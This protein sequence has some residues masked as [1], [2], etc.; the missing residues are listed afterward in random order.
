MSDDFGNEKE[1]INGKEWNWKTFKTTEGFPISPELLDWV[2]GQEKAIEECKLC[3]DEWVRKLQWLKERQ[4]WKAFEIVEQRKEVRFRGHHLFN[5]RGK[6]LTFNPKPQP[7]EYLPAGPFL[8]LLGDAGTGK[9]LIGRAMSG[10]M[11]NIYK[12]NGIGLYDVCS[13]MNKT[14]PSEPKIS[15]HP[16]PQGTAIVKKAHKEEQKKGA[17][18]RFFFNFLIALMMGVGLF[19]LGYIFGGAVMTWAF[20]W[21]IVID[22]AGHMMSVQLYYNGNMLKFIMDTAVANVQMIYIG[23]GALSMGGMLWLFSKMFGFLGGK[24]KQGIGGSEATKAPKLLIDNS[25]GTATFVD[26][27]GH[28]SSQLFGSIAWD[29]YQT[30]DLGTP[31]HQR[32]TAGDVHRAHLGVLYIDEIKNLSGAEAITLLTVLEDGQLPIALRSHSGMSGDSITG[33]AMIFFK[34][35]GTIRYGQF[36]ELIKSFE[37]NNTIEVLSPEYMDFKC[38]KLVWT[39][40]LKVFRRGKK[41]IK[42]IKLIGGKSIRLT[43]DHSLFRYNNLHNQ[44]PL[45]PTTI[46]YGKCITVN[47]I[48]IPKVDMESESENDLEFYGYWI[49]DGHFEADNTIGLATGKSEEDRSFIYAY[50]EKL[51][52]TASLKNDKGDIRIYSTRLVRKMKTLG[53]VSGAFAKRIPEWIFFLP[54][55]KVKAFIK[56]YRRSDGSRYRKDRRMITQFGSVNRKLLEDFQTLFSILGIETS[57]SSGRL[58]GKKAFKSLNLQYKLTIWKD[59]SEDFEVNHIRNQ[60]LLSL[61][62]IRKIIDVEEET[63]VFDI[64]TGNECFIANGILCHNTAAMAVA[65]EPVPCMVFLIAAGNMD[66]VPMIHAALM[67]RIRGYGKIVYMNNDMENNILNRRK[68]VQFMSQEIKRFNLLPFTRKACMEIISEA[69]K[70]SGRNDMLTCKF[71]PMI[72]VI[73][74]AST[75]AANAGEKEVSE[76]YVKEAVCNHCKSVAQQMLEREIE[77]QNIYRAIDPNANPKVGQIYGLAV[78]EAD[79]GGEMIG[80]VLPLKASIVKKKKDKSTTGLPDFTVTGVSATEGSWAQNSIQKVRHVF[81]QMYKKDPATDFI[82]HIDFAQEIGVDGPSAGAAMT[83]ALISAYTK[84]RIKQDVAVTGEINIAIDG[85]IL[86]T[87]IGGAHEKIMAAQKRGFKTVCIPEVNYNHNINPADYTIRIVPCKTIEDY[88]KEVFE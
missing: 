16:S 74:T 14:M 86:I 62:R 52:I 45:I 73:K 36:S 15:I 42:D 25:S 77:L 68:Y 28:G 35:N 33:D 21:D 30:G 55:N 8:L 88:I 17:G 78:T 79:I 80:S 46:E 58:N 19:F 83:L 43:E 85:E 40:V 6:I 56:G 20:N 31:E 23:I 11:T 22:W 67:D 18:V 64:S 81:I 50:A 37:N 38:K 60:G 69:R 49:G 70:K 61:H 53:F 32:V 84:K 12:K 54:E 3:I 66:S 57:I 5:L 29:P 75:L 7:K 51:G 13:W 41:P 72:S 76:K 71:R 27:T 65:T 10:Y 44:K 63:E 59:S 1:I 2:I 34:E 48:E 24:G 4:W 9:S 82:T 39:P 47:K 26:A 87:P